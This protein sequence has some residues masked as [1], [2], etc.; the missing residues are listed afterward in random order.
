MPIRRL[1]RPVCAATLILLSIQTNAPGAGDSVAWRPSFESAWSEAQSQGRP[2]WIQFTGPWCVY[3]RLMDA[4]A[5]VWPPV[6][7]TASGPLVAVKVRADEREDLMAHYGLTALPATVVLAPTG[8]VLARHQGYLNRE[9][10]H[11]LLVDAQKRATAPPPLALRGLCPVTLVERGALVAGLAALQ[12]VYDG[13]LYRFADDAARARFQQTPEKFVP[14]NSGLCVV[15]LVLRRE[16]RPGDPRHGVYYR[17][18]L[19]L[20]ADE[21]ARTAFASA[22]ERYGQIDIAR[23][24][25]CVHC[26]TPE[27]ER[28]AGDWR[29]PLTLRGKRYLFPDDSHR[30]AF[31]A[32]PERYLR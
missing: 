5:L 12:E 28:V 20:C 30:Q 9:S 3:C 29:F 11:A 13:Q 21:A 22:P 14:S 15:S 18:R 10:L 17:G 2:L 19:F 16:A 31:R 27:A 26:A 6:V 32:N 25:L 1:G 23:D 7:A 24:G 4:E 8:A